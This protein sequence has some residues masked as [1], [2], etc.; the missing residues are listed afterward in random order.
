MNEKEIVRTENI[1]SE[2]EIN[3]ISMTREEF[4]E[5]LTIS[6]RKF[7]DPEVQEKLRNTNILIAGVGSIGNPIAMMA[8]RSG[9]EKVT[10]M[11]PDV[12]EANNL[13]RQQYTI[14]QLGRNKADMTVENLKLINPF[15]SDTVESVKEGMTIENARRYVESADIVIDA[16]DIRALDIV[17]ELHKQAAILKKPVLVG[18]DLAG[19]AMIAVYRYD[20]ENIKPLKGE[21]TDEKIEEF[22]GVN[23]AYKDGLISNAEFL[24]YVYDAFTGPVPPLKVPV[25]QLNELIDRD[26]NDGRTYQLGTTSTLLSALAIEAVRKIINNEDIKDVIIVDVPSEVRRSNPS[27]ISRI[28]LLLR[29][30]SVIKKRSNEVKE[31]LE[32]IR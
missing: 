18:Y 12:V 17:Y 21:L 3:G 29:T 11:D 10:V 5:E 28:P 22:N 1:S 8:V 19:T 15:I 30:L 32:K 16:V 26:S 2:K 13:S 23:E 9:A 31:T 14:N 4:Y 24:N 27:V 25:E 7:I 20:K 6:S